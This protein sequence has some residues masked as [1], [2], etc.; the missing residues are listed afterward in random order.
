MSTQW[1]DALCCT[2][3]TYL[4]GVRGPKSG[5]FC[6]LYWH[7]L[8]LFRLRYYRVQVLLLRQLRDH[9]FQLLRHLN[10]AGAVRFRV[11]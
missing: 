4:P 6:I 5:G 7:L 8:L 2:R 3:K 10:L 9:V 1:C 11:C